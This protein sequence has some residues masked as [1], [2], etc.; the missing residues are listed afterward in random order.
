MGGL[1]ITPDKQKVIVAYK[2]YIAAYDANSGKLLQE[3]SNDIYGDKPVKNV[4][5]SNDKSLFSFSDYGKHIA[6][7]LHD[8]TVFDLEKGKCIELLY[9]HFKGIELSADG[10]KLYYIKDLG[11]FQGYLWSESDVLVAQ[12]PTETTLNL[13]YMMDGLNRNAVISP[14]LNL[15]AYSVDDRIYIFHR[16]SSLNSFVLKSHQSDITQLRWL[17]NGVLVSSGN[18]NTIRFW[19]V[20]KGVELAK[21]ILLEAT[22]NWVIVTHARSI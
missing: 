4:E 14:D 17:Q 18:D 5:L 21:L 11:G 20:K 15:T 8:L 19:D 7:L 22:G 1:S 9:G 3:I 10:Q 16:Q 6:V 2:N 12:P 13:S